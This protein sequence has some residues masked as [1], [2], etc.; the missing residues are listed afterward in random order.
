MLYRP[1]RPGVRALLHLGVHVNGDA[2]ALLASRTR[3]IAAAVDPTL[4]LY[5]VMTPGSGG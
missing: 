3:T 1:G 4:R 5:D 2:H